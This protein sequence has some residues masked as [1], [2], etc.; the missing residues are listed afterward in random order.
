VHISQ[1]R[2]EN[3]RAFKDTGWLDLRPITIL[4]GANNS[5]KSSILAPLL[6]LKQTLRSP[7]SRTPL[8]LRG[9][10]INAGSFS[11]ISYL[12]HL[13]GNVSFGFTMHA[14]RSLPD[15]LPELGVLPPGNVRITFQA[16]SSPGVVNLDRY[17]VE[18]LAGRDMLVRAKRASKRY[19]I[20]KFAWAASQQNGQAEAANKSD[21][22]ARRGIRYSRPHHFLFNSDAILR[23]AVPVSAASLHS[24]RG[25]KRED[26][27]TFDVTEVTLSSY[28]VRYTAVV[29]YVQD[30][31]TSF[32]R[33]VVYLGPLR[34]DPKR[35][36][37]VSGDPPSDVGVRGQFS[38]EMILRALNTELYPEVN[39]WL[40]NFG[41]K[42]SLECERLT[43]T[44]FSLNL[45]PDDGAAPTN[46]AD[47]G[48]GFSQILPLIVQGLAADDDTLLITEQ[49]EIHLNPRLQSRLAEFLVEIA[50]KGVSILAETHS[51]HLILGIRRLV[52]EQHIKAS[53]VA[54]YYVENDGQASKARLV[55]LHK[56]GHIEDRDW[57][58][59][60]FE[61]SLRESLA[62]A[63]AQIRGKNAE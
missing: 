12:H 10:L 62:L 50:N 30:H 27:V 60:F 42:G 16:A 39:R 19:S 15:E 52:A 41:L 8:V 17:E 31:V 34:E 55:E 23:D 26:V 58:R 4:I 47:V 53:D 21:Q 61:D 51:E 45:R 28:V 54:I 33:N 59:G 13:E 40:H 43:D 11:D 35:L 22:A 38:A 44:A 49:P 37:Q 63:T 32:L 5:G 14:Q 48:F 29:E 25:S 1:L 36:Y 2:W 57:P 9:D 46:F 6:M 24:R 7:R 20:E 3:F 18:D 56:N